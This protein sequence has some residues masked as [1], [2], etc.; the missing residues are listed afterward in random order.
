MGMRPERR[1]VSVSGPRYRAK[2]DVLGQETSDGF[3]LCD[4]STQDIFEL[5]ETA[6]RIWELVVEETTVD[7]MVEILMDEY[8]ATEEQIRESVVE[9]I[10]ELV[11]QGLVTKS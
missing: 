7:R 11:D 5:N 4:A 3:L 9:T 2:A 1:R 8:D 6:R 10:E